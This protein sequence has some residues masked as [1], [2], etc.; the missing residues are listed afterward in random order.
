[1]T[2]EEL[3]KTGTEEAHQTALFAMC[4]MNKKK[5]PELEWIH[6]VPNGGS[7]GSTPKHAMIVGAKMKA[8]GV[9]AGVYDLFLPVRRGDWSGLYIE[10][11]KPG[12]L[13]TKNQGRSDEQVAFAEFVETQGFATLVCDNWES[14][15]N[16]IVQ[17]LEWSN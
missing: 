15:W 8:T 9:K 1:M 12:K 14:A 13:K 10:L 2:P 16:A 4:S 3:S 11:K 7:R 5:Y 6:A 17:Y